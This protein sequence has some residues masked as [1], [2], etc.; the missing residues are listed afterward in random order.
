MFQVSSDD[1]YLTIYAICVQVLVCSEQSSVQCA[2]QYS[3]YCT[4]VQIEQGE[5]IR[6]YACVHV[7]GHVYYGL[8]S[9]GIFS[10]IIHYHM[11]CV[12]M[13]GACFKL[14]CV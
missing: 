4:L 8:L 5:I 9:V 13:F 7:H 3:G 14:I 2:V 11:I 6:H 10:L 12:C 1:M